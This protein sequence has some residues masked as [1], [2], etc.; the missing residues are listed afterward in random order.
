MDYAKNMAFV[1]PVE[2]LAD[3]SE[4]LQLYSCWACDLRVMSEYSCVCASAD[5][6]ECEDKSVCLGGR[7]TNAVG[8]FS[9]SCPS[10]MELVDGSACRGTHTHTHSGTVRQWERTALLAHPDLHVFVCRHRWV[11]NYSGTLW[12]RRLPEHWGLLHVR[13]S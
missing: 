13:L 12:R 9:C 2:T 1:M 8:S 4:A 6:N 11:F 5:V 3:V 10:G 7:C